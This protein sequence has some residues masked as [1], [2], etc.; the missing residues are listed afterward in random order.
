MTNQNPLKRRNLLGQAN[1]KRK[2]LKVKVSAKVPDQK[3]HQLPQRKAESECMFNHHLPKKKGN[4]NL[5]HQILQEM[6]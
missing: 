3:V 6:Q 2:N 1:K 5:N 4:N